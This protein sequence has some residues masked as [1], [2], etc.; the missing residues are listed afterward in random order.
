MK[1]EAPSRST[2]DSEHVT[3]PTSSMRTL[4]GLA[5]FVITAGLGIVIWAIATIPHYDPHLDAN[6]STIFGSSDWLAYL[7]APR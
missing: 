3:A 1:T 7:R 4:W 2:Q 5:A 6:L